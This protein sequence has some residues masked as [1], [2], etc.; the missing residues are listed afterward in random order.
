MK[1]LHV[2]SGL[3]TG[4]AEIN[5]VELAARLQERGHPQHIISLSSAGPLV[6]VARG[7]GVA[8]TVCGLRSLGSL[9]RSVYEIFSVARRL[10]PAVIQGWMY[11]GNLAATLLHF[12]APGRAGRTLFWNIRASNM[13]SERYARVI[14]LSALASRWPSMIIAN[15]KAGADFHRLQGFTPRQLQIVANGIDTARFRPDAEARAQVR[16][17]LSVRPDEILVVH[18]ARVDPM[19]NHALFLSAMALLPHVKGVLVGT[20]TEQLDL[21]ANVKAV[22]NRSDVERYYQAGDMVASSSSYGEGFSNS[23]AE[24]M[25]A[26]LVPV[27]TDVGD[28]IGIAGETGKVVLPDDASAYFGALKALTSLPREELRARGVA[29]RARISEQFSIDRAVTTY[30]GL[31]LRDG[32]KRQ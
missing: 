27:A 2:I 9:P 22:G 26:G 24:G 14:R 18:V 32:I 15:S 4:G 21:P 28:A 13:D 7:R 20:G 10:R 6:D 8:V 29:A 17:A 23:I 19:K 3:G 5:L 31:Y 16:A 25:S 1:V 11:H 30:E 12:V